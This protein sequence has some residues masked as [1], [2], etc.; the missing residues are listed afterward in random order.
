MSACD[1]ELLAMVVWLLRR[2]RGGRELR[3]IRAVCR[4]KREKIGQE[5]GPTMGRHG[6]QDRNGNQ[7]MNG[8]VAG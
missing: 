5:I 8:L 3:K 4:G 7:G 1:G 6:N 2:A